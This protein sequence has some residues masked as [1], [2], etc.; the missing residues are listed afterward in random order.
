MSNTFNDNYQKGFFKNNKRKLG[1]ISQNLEKLHIQY[2]DKAFRN[3]NTLWA[4]YN[5][6]YRGLKGVLGD[7][8]TPFLQ[9]LQTN[10]I[11]Y[12]STSRERR[13]FNENRQRY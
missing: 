2:G 1:T 5:Y 6:E 9:W 13:K 8:F 11:A 10:S 7:K 3:D 12:N 4:M